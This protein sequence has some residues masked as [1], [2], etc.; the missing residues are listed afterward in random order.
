MDGL[1]PLLLQM[2]QMLPMGLPIWNAVVVYAAD[3]RNSN[4]AAA[5]KKLLGTIK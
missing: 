1:R 4:T 5:A 2:L 3:A